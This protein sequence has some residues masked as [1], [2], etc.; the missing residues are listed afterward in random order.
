MFVEKCGQKLLHATIYIEVPMHLK[1][2]GDKNYVSRSREVYPPLSLS[3]RDLYPFY[4]LPI[5]TCSAT[6]AL[7]HARPWFIA[8][9]TRYN[10]YVV[11]YFRETR[12]DI[13]FPSDAGR[14]VGRNIVCDEGL[15]A[16]LHTTGTITDEEGRRGRK[17]G[18]SEY[19]IMKHYTRLVIMHYAVKGI[20]EAGNRWETELLLASSNFNVEKKRGVSNRGARET[21]NIALP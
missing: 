16:R 13:F 2:I 12:G 6:R 4:S 1:D 19:T 18:K 11:K 5:N 21:K 17:R 9:L 7:W 15:Y 10:G 3:P 14:R 20:T 8:S